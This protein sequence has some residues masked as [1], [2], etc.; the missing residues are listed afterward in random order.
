MGVKMNRRNI[1]ILGIL[2]I[3]IYFIVVTF[4]VITSSQNWLII[5][6]ILTMVSGMYFIF[7]IIIL[8][9]S[10]NENKKIYKLMSIIFVTGLMF[11]TNIA[12]IFNLTVIKIIENGTF[13]PDYLQIGKIP[14]IVFSIEHFGWGIFLGLS[15]LFSSFGI[16][17]LNKNK[18]IKITLK[19]C[20]GLCF[21]GYFGTLLNENL[22]YIASVG[23]SFGVITICIEIILLEK[24]KNKE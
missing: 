7:F 13:V 17:N 22:W 9:F 11:F 8:P 1:A 2:L 14:S 5:F 18:P 19:I 3:C 24:I 4:F 6:E 21:I 16:E 23:Y 15:F 20:A 12:H 10:N